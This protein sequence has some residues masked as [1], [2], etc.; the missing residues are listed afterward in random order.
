M[1]LLSL[2]VGSG[3]TGADCPYGL[4]G[5]DNLAEV[6]GAEV[7][8]AVDNL[9]LDDFEVLVSFALGKNLTDAEDRCQAV[10]ESQGNFGAEGLGGLAI[11]LA[12]LRVTED[13]VTGTGAGYHGCADFAGIGTALVVGAVFGAEAEFALFGDDV[14]DR[15]QVGEGYADYDI[16]LGLNALECLVDFFGEFHALRNGGVHFPVSCNNVL[17]H[18]GYTVYFEC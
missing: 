5:E 9:S 6:L 14:V 4:V 16:A 1:H 18:F 17:S 12:A 8:E 10:L 13:N 3:L 15:Y 11:V 7:E 2:V